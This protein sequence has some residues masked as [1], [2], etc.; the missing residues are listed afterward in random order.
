MKMVF[1]GQVSGG[2]GGQKGVRWFWGSYKVLEGFR[3]NFQCCLLGYFQSL[4]QYLCSVDHLLDQSQEYYARN[5]G[6][7]STVQYMSCL[8]I[9]CIPDID[10]WISL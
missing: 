9:C 4:T 10:S 2:S 6:L 8:S 3:M 5:G 7:Q 1:I